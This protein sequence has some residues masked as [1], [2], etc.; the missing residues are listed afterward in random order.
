MCHW[1]ETIKIENGQALNL[2]WHQ[3]RID[4]TLQHHSITPNFHLN[5]FFNTE[6]LPAEGVYRLRIEYH[7]TIVDHRISPYAPGALNT[8]KIVEANHLTYNFKSTDRTHLESL[9]LQRENCDDVLI[10]KNKL[11]TDI[12]YANIVFITERQFLSPIK[13]LLP[14][15]QISLLA[16]QGIIHLCEI[17]PSDL[18]QFKGWIPVNALLG[19]NP[20]KSRPIGSIRF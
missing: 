12:S 7:A 10:V 9:K 11:I 17:Q 1:F 15:T 20:H 14:G 5:D 19:F 16:E 8:L 13:P 6:R 18:K 4:S 3:K 2:K